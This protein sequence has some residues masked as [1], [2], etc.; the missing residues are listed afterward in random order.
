MDEK[1]EQLT[2]TTV[3]FNHVESMLLWQIGYM[4][5]RKQGMKPLTLPQIV[6]Q[7][8]MDAAKFR[9]L[10]VINPEFSL[11]VIGNGNE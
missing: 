10:D 7:C 4:E 2:R 6:R 3:S 8:V 9:G 1:Q 5:M 11:P